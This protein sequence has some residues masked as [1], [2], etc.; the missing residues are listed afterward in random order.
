M[1]ENEF[2]TL[3]QT[4]LTQ[5]VRDRIPGDSNDIEFTQAFQPTQQDRPEGRAVYFKRLFGKRHGWPG[6]AYAFQVG[7]DNFDRAESQIIETRYQFS[8]TQPANTAPDAITHNDILEG[9]AAGLQSQRFIAYLKANGAQVLRII[10]ITNVPFKNDQ[11]QFEDYPTF[12]AI[13]LYTNEYVDEVAK[14]TAT[15]AKIYPI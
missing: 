1:R 14:L 8:V 7:R 4:A 3:L 10:D 9:V 15:E 11:D 12:D 6:T 5:F 13:F 2:A